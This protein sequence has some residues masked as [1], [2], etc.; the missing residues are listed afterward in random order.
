LE[1]WRL[2]DGL[3]QRVRAERGRLFSEQLGVWFGWD[4]DRALVRIWTAGGQMRPTP[5]EREQQLDEA[6]Q[7]AAEEQ[8]L[9]QEAEQRAASE[10][11]ARREA[12][13]RAAVEAQA[14][15]EAEERAAALAA[16]LERLRRG[17][18]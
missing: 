15:R 18:A 2:E 6:E 12:E 13:E 3:Y 17:G 7:R 11:Q 9:R 16:E 1:L 10:A 4:P 14:R 8:R 5:Q